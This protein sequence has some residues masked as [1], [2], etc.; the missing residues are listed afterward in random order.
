MTLTKANIVRAVSDQ[1]GFTRKQSRHS[2][3]S[4]VEIIKSTLESGESI[5]IGHF[6]R[7]DIIEKKGRPWRSPFTGRIMMLPARRTVKFK[8]FKRLK[9]KINGQPM[10]TESKELSRTKIQPVRTGVISH[11]ELRKILAAHRRWLDSNGKSGQKA[12]LPRAVLVSVD[13]YAAK[14]AH[15]DLKGADLQEALLSEADLYEADLR[16]AN[17]TDAVL[18]WACLDYARLQQASLK[19]ADLRWAN[20]EGANL[21]G[22]DLRFANLEGA[23]LNDARLTEANLY[24]MSMKNTDMK[25]AILTKIKLDYE[26]QLNLP[27]PVFDEYRQTFRILE[28]TPVLSHSY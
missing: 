7:F 6:G 1:T 16:R 25:G 26:T 11:D 8:T 14:L 2:V 9:D 27:K 4:L 13:L 15:I 20:L 21:S 19:G 17:L 24:G 18:D 23:N 3:N 5:K 10:G 28:W 22:C 12:V